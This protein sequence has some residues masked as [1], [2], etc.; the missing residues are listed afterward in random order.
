ML[1]ARAEG[2]GAAARLLGYLDASYARSGENRGPTEEKIPHALLDALSMRFA[3]DDM[4]V[5]KAEGAAWTES[6]AVRFASD[7]IAASGSH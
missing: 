2:Y 7:Y 5:Y 6:Q 4:Q 1:A 3:D